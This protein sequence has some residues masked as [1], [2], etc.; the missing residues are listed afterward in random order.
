MSAGVSLIYSEKTYNVETQP[1]NPTNKLLKDT[2]TI[3]NIDYN[4]MVE[5]SD[6]VV[7]DYLLASQK[8][9]IV[10]KEG[11]DTKRLKIG[12][13][14]YRFNKDKAISTKLKNKL[15]E[16][17]RTMDYKNMNSRKREN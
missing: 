12:D 4:I 13:T 11:K 16:V 10:K 17:K 5:R 14:T 3:E 15:N 1:S 7:L 2:F 9:E 8:G 6:R